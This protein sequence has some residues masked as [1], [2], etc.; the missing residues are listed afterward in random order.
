MLE[1]EALISSQCCYFKRSM[2]NQV[3]LSTVFFSYSKRNWRLYG[4]FNLFYP[5][6]ESV[7][8]C[9]AVAGARV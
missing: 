4:L 6:T 8:I 3:N 7:H 9:G 2:P 1:K 5:M